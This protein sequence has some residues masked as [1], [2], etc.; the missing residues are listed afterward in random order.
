MTALV[1]T[2][3]RA[4]TIRGGGDRLNA[5]AHSAAWFRNEIYVGTTRANLSLIKHRSPGGLEPWPTRVPTDIYDHDLRAQI[6][7]FDPEAATLRQAFRSPLIAA[8]SS[9]VPR[10]LGYRGMAV[11]RSHTDLVLALYAAGWASARSGRAPTLLRSYDGIE[12]S[13]VATLGNDPSLTSYR[14]LLAH[15]GRLYAAPTGRL[16]GAA[17][18]AGEAVLMTTRSPQR[19]R[20]RPALALPSNVGDLGVVEAAPFGGFLYASTINPRGFSL[21]RCRPE[22]PPPYT[23]TQVMSK[24]ADRGPTNEAALSLCAFGDALYV[25]TAIQNGGFDRTYKIG[26]AAAELLRVHPDGSWDLLAGE[27]RMTNMGEKRPLSG[28]GPG[29][30]NPFNAYIWKLAVHDGWLY[31]ST[32]NWAVFLPYLRLADFP[33]MRSRLTGVDR[34]RLAEEWGGF[35]LWRTRDG[36]NWTPIMRDGFGT[37]YN[38]GGRSL[39]STPHGLA[40][41]TANPFGPE[42]AVRAAGRWS[43]APNPR[44]GFELWLGVA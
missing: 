28:F 7:A 27:S 17:N 1:A 12:F 2:D 36:V 26:P 30:D 37:P 33:D 39:V 4:V 11:F 13:A 10:E 16:G 14:T 40:V 32:Y 29:F 44:G 19:G 41:G 21:W 6:L 8:G 24:G 3:F 43:Y 20:W 34:F 38:F 42:V 9:E 25:G 15:D 5:Y 22:G 35:E 23:W 18:V 31:A